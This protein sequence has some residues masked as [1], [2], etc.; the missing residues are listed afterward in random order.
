M[1]ERMARRA[2][3][4]QD[5][6]ARELSVLE[7]TVIIHDVKPALMDQFILQPV[8]DDSNLYFRS[9]HSRTLNTLNKSY[10]LPVDQDEVKVLF[11]F[12]VITPLL[13]L[14]QRSE[15]HHRL[16]QFVFSGRTYVGP[17]KEALQFG[18]QR[19]GRCFGN[20]Q[21]FFSFQIQS[22]TWGQ[23]LVL[24]RSLKSL[25]LLLM[26]LYRA[27]DIADEFPRVEVVAVDLAPIQ[28]QYVALPNSLS[29]NFA[30]AVM[31]PLTARMHGII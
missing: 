18:Q 31:S 17:V 23:V 11:N 10:L 29:A 21:T 25:N 3:D 4:S 19:R 13:I 5:Q 14:V 12:L 28:P 1:A 8:G 9:L 27:I 26:Y 30:S 24:G 2:A 22:S 15:I 16:L 7:L 6:M 20:S